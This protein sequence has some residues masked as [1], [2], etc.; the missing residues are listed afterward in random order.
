MLTVYLSG[1]LD[2]L[3]DGSSQCTGKQQRNAL[4]GYLV[5]RRPL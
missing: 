2:S 3:V 5:G 1:F 4:L